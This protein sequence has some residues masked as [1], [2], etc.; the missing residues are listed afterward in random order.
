MSDHRE[1]LDAFDSPTVGIAGMWYAQVCAPLPATE[2]GD[3]YV[4]IPDIDGNTQWGPCFWQP[5]STFL[6]IDVAQ[7]LETPN[8]FDVAAIKLPIVGSECL[9]I[10]DNRQHL[11]VVA[12]Q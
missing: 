2:L 5:R 8:P 1:L 7:D 10:F 11:W 9:V 3:L 12:W 6:T 4:I